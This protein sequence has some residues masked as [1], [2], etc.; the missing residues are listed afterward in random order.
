MCCEVEV[1]LVKLWLVKLIVVSE[2]SEI[3]CG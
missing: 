1:V 3:N 2:V